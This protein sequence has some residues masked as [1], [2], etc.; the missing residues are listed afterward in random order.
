MG[1][2]S[3]RF[4]DVAFILIFIIAAMAMGNGMVTESL[5]HDESLFARNVAA[6]P[7]GYFIHAAPS[8]PAFYFFSWMLTQCFGMHE[9]V[10]RVIPFLGGLIALGT[11]LR[12]L[13]RRFS[14]FAALTAGLLM[15]TAFPVIHY[16]GNAHPYAVDMA[17]SALLFVGSLS[18]IEKPTQAGFW[19]WIALAALAVLFSFPAFFFV[20]GWAVYLVLRDVFHR[21]L[22]QLKSR[23]PG[24]TALA[25]LMLTL[26]VLLFFKQAD[27]RVDMT[28]WLPFLPASFHPVVLVKWLYFNTLDLMGYLF[29]HQMGG[30]IGLVGVLT[31][32][33]VLFQR[34]KHD[35]ALL[36]LIPWGL[37]ILAGMMHKWPYGATRTGCFLIP[38]F[39]VLLAALFDHLWKTLATNTTSRVILIFTAMALLFPYAWTWKYAAMPIDDNEEAVRTLTAS[40]LPA[41]QPE[42]GFIVYYAANTQFQFYFREAVDRASIMTWDHK[43]N[44]AM[45][46]AFVV[47]H[48][49]DPGARFWIVVSHVHQE[50][51]QWMISEASAHGRLIQRVEAAGCAA[52]L[53]ER[54]LDVQE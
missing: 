10:Y 18:L 17:F 51:D 26:F 27:N 44:E 14:A 50:E 24:W 30:I 52:L 15:A 19:R 36:A 39:I 53:Y 7:D 31:G 20:G 9:W 40:V 35:A 23:W 38:L 25:V 13:R 6:F 1:I 21:D 29:W 34:R 22:T 2:S 5:L 8:A 48:L 41:V 46:R 12:F 37:A 43:E 33:A 45:I 4:L 11:M 3:R 32:A 54:I 28:D 47:A 42:D 49:P 16:G